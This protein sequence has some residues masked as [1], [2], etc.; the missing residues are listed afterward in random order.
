MY[1]IILVVM[2][3]IVGIS[4]YAQS[5]N[6]TL[7]PENIGDIT[8]IGALS[9]A[10][11][12]VNS[13]VFSADGRYIIA[14]SDDTSLRVWDVASQ[15][16]TQEL[17][18]HNTYV[19]GVALHPD[20]TMVASVSWD[21]QV[22]LYD[23]E[24]GILDQTELL[25]GYM[26]V[27]DHIVFSGNGE[28][29]SFGIGNGILMT[30]SIDLSERFITPLDSLS[31]TALTALPSADID[32][33]VLSTGFPD[34]AL[35]VLMGDEITTLANPHEGGV[36]ALAFSPVF[37]ETFTLASAGDDSTI[38]LWELSADA[39]RPQ[40]VATMNLL[41]D[42]WYTALA[43]HP[44]G[45]LLIATTVEGGLFVWDMTGETPTEVLA[46]QTEISISALAIN[47][48]GTIIA[49]GHDDG[50]IMLWGIGQ[51]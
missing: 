42:V 23:F 51:E 36:T 46:I 27:I 32:L 8:Q 18:P 13:M 12:A 9:G 43:Y 24:D 41:E 37:E 19:K 49:T 10:E 48:D 16:Q 3:F 47:A 40:L 39:L 17:F 4:V 25:T 45:E 5:D 1:K 31:I 50:T 6:A 15:A 2:L 7:S 14:G 30:V 26:S 28:W 29:F 34:D 21:M 11:G 44:S 35:M 22:I 33:I 38:R 20:G